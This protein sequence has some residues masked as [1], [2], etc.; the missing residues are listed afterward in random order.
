M[1]L[2][3]ISFIQDLNQESRSRRKPGFQDQAYHEE[4][5]NLGIYIR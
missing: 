1:N 3:T 5:V 4:L 2:K